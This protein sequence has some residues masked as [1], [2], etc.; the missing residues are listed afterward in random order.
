MDK[1]TIAVVGLLA[2]FLLIWNTVILPSLPEEMLYEKSTVQP[3]ST[4]ANSTELNHEQISKNI[5]QELESRKESALTELKTAV[6]APAIKNLPEQFFIVETDL[7]KVKFS[8]KG[9]H[10]SSLSMKEFHP[11]V[12]KVEILTL[13]QDRVALS[14]NDDLSD[15]QG[16][17]NQHQKGQ[18]LIL[19]NQNKKLIYRFEN[20]SYFF[21]LEVQ[22]LKSNSENWTINLPELQATETNALATINRG[23]NGAIA[24]LK[25]R[26]YGDSSTASTLEELPMA[27]SSPVG[28]LIYA[29]FRNKYFAL[30]IEP[31]E[32]NSAS[33]NLEFF[34]D[35]GKGSLKLTSKANTSS[36]YRI[37]S[38]PLNK[39]ILYDLDSEKYGPLFN[40]T[41]I[42]IIIHFLL[43]LLSF[44]NSIPGINMGLA[45]ILLTLTVKAV[46]FPMNLKAQTSMFMMSK[47]SPKI[48]ELQE[49]YK[50]DRQQLGVEQ[51]KLFKENG[52]NPLAGCLPMF[53]QMPV[54][55]SLFSTVGEGFPLRHA[56]FFDWIQ[57]LSAPDQF[58]TLGFDMFGLGNGD[59]TTNLNLLVVLYIITMLV[60]Q[61]M[62]PKSEDPQQQQMQKMM[63]FMMIGFAVILYNYSSGLML[64]FVG[65]NTLGMAESW[66]IRNRVLPA[67]DKKRQNKK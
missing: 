39:S 40:Y 57:D 33:H 12:E 47:I 11:T 64:Y 41:G 30:I 44:Y 15:M 49:K 1:K 52:V 5:E 19:W 24:N 2:A 66:Y 58:M 51:M 17:L 22:I 59:G 65:S 56:H 38:G 60:Q 67:M 27:F 37:F 23:T 14:I 16:E 43:G 55:I 46:L 29:G 13:I 4:T 18:T 8:S 34:N 42:N 7:L 3:S 26:D 61:S 36:K 10:L 63:K 45:I 50:N 20:G 21:D 62:M 9:G 53:I 48:K 6:S 31:Q 35:E 25:Q 28:D 32:S 54:L